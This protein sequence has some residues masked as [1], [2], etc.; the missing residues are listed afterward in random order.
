MILPRANLGKACIYI[1]GFEQS[2]LG[3]EPNAFS[4]WR[5]H[6]VQDENTV[7]IINQCL[8]DSLK[9]R[10]ERLQ[11]R[12]AALSDEVHFYILAYSVGCHLAARLAIDLRERIKSFVLIAPDPKFR[13]NDLDDIQ[14]P[15]AFNQVK[16]LW[17][18]LL[19]PSE[20]FCAKL[21]ALSENVKVEIVYSKDDEI[22]LWDG[23]TEIMEQRCRGDGFV[24]SEVG[25]VSMA[26]PSGMFH[27]GLSP[28][29]AC[30][31]FWIHK[32]LFTKAKLKK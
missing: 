8:G 29:T 14:S 11:K 23:N 18:P 15:S 21:N 25:T 10:W 31:E 19:D 7:L 1:D 26:N 27:V 20:R 6:F 5:N 24:W 3:D 17:E 4:E 12:L 32:Q 13:T 2:R 28:Q 22:A 9:N 30:S 16:V